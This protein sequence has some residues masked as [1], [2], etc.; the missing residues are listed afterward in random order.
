VS[1]AA[2]TKWKSNEAFYRV[3]NLILKSPCLNE[4]DRMV[5]SSYKMQTRL[6]APPPE[7]LISRW[8]WYK[9]PDFSW[10]KRCKWSLLFLLTFN[11]LTYSLVVAVSEVVCIYFVVCLPFVELNLSFTIN[12]NQLCRSIISL[13]TSIGQIKPANKNIWQLNYFWCFLFH[14]WLVILIFS[15]DGWLLLVG[16]SC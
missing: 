5:D 6:I 3:C 8:I 7:W 12:S 13:Q 4:K 15:M 11:V 14:I 10:N 2:D 16:N 1:A 9:T